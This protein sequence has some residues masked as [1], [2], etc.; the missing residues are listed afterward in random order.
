MA[1]LLGLFLGGGQSVWTAL[2]NRSIHE[3][4]IED[5]GRAKPEATWLRVTNGDMRVLDAAYSEGRFDKEAKEVFVPYMASGKSPETD[6][7]H[8]IVKSKRPSLIRMVSDSRDL[9]KS[10]PAG[11]TEADK[12]QAGLEFLSEHSG[13]MSFGE[14]VEGMVEFG[15]ESNDNEVAKLRKLFPTLAPNFVVLKEGGKPEMR[16]GIFMLLAGL[17]LAVF[18]FRPRR[19][20]VP[21]QAM[22]PPPPPPPGGA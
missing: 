12:L 2:K 17:A 20:A 5:F 16:V 6:P 15:I 21:A 11:A 13:A 19:A 8:V 14:P 10:L 18:V 4:S 1:I 22:N 9:E 3:I 7:I